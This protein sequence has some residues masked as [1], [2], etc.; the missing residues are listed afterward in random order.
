MPEINT[1]TRVLSSSLEQVSTHFVMYQGRLQPKAQCPAM[2]LQRMKPMMP[3]LVLCTAG[4]NNTLVCNHPGPSLLPPSVS[5]QR[6]SL[7]WGDG[8]TSQTFAQVSWLL[9]HSVVLKLFF[10]WLQ[11]NCLTNWSE[12]T[13]FGYLPCHFPPCNRTS[14]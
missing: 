11:E 4:D 8:S 7:L 13:K 9:Q 3:C 6:M 2:L 1:T 12:T 10:W 14:K 5:L